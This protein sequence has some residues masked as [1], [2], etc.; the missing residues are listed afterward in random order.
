MW[1][2][3]EYRYATS[4]AEAMS[5]LRQGPGKGR[6]IAGGTD[7]FLFPPDDCDFVVDINGAGLDEIALTVE[8]DL[9]LGAAAS[10]QAIAG[11]PLVAAYAG[12]AVGAAALQCGNRPVRT[13]ATVGGNLCNA[14][15]S[16]DM[17]PILLALEASVHI[18]D[19]EQQEKRP[20]RE[21]FTAPR[22]SILGDR[23]LV[24][25][26]LPRERAA[27]LAQAQKLT[28]V[29]E[30]ISLVQVAVALTL[31][32]TEVAGAGIAL[33]AVAAVPLR[34]DAAEQALAGFDLS[35]P[36]VEAKI[37]AAAAA[38]GDAASPIDDHR[39]SAEYRRAMVV[40]LTR[41]LLNGLRDSVMGEGTCRS[42]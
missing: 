28:R 27:A 17:A 8:G 14:L 34:A 25:V 24:G 32:G 16:A 5:L 11:S 19:G 3:R 20:L 10:L 39:A 41:R 9:F 13:V 29:V 33:G 42:S 23:L 37:T 6:F 36:D 15:P 7:L 38:A 30:D 31:A 40:V 22:Q 18:T 35:G 12:G 2:L 1:D 21:F 26:S 4:A